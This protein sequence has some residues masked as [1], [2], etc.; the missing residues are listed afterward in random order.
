MVPIEDFSLQSHKEKNHA[1]DPLALYFAL[2]INKNGIKSNLSDGV[3][4]NLSDG[5][6]SI[7]SDGVKSN[8]SDGV[9]SNLSDG[10]KI[11]E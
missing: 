6:K 9:K 11:L 5:V 1:L 10:V 8:L 7:L 3:K 4:S 2:H